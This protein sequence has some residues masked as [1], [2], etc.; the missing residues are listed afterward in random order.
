M[1]VLTFDAGT[2]RESAYFLGGVFGK[3]KLGIVMV[4]SE[5]MTPKLRDVLQCGRV[6]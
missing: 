6:A 4:K 1:S 5:A 3:P 2:S